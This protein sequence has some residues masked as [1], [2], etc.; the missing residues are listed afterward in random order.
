[1]YVLVVV[2]EAGIYISHI[3]WR[4]CYRKLRKEAKDSGK[5]IDDLLLLRRNDTQETGDIEK[6]I[7]PVALATSP[8][9]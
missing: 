6:G 7:I 9:S 3:S 1:M 2:L 4:I 8:S 5:S